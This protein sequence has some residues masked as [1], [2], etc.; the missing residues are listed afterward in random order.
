VLKLH[1]SCNFVTKGAN[2]QRHQLSARGTRVEL[3]REEL[4]VG[5]SL[6]DA[7]GIKKEEREFP[8]MS[9][10]SPEKD[11]LSATAKLSQMRASWGQLV[12]AA[13]SVVIIGVRYNAADTHITKPLQ[14]AHGRIFY[15]GSEED[16]RIWSRHVDVTSLGSTFMKALPLR[17]CI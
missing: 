4:P 10:T 14:S 2:A 6:G 9:L 1:G 3:G 5:P 16:L 15:V 7:L 11:T 17:L 13:S 8:V 12:I